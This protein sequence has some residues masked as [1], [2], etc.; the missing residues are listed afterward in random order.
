MSDIKWMAINY[1]IELIWS[2]EEECEAVSDKLQK[3]KEF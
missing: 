2:K 3:C 1:I